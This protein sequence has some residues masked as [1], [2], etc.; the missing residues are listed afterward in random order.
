MKITA[1]Y[2]RTN[3]RLRAQG[4]PEMTIERFIESITRLHIKGLLVIHT[5]ETC[6][7]C[8]KAAHMGGVSSPS[9]SNSPATSSGDQ[10]AHPGDAGPGCA[11]Y[12]VK[13]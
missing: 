8:E 4:L 7:I 13:G 6:V 10:T 3:A 9:F 12:A 1:V 5:N 2:N 11:S